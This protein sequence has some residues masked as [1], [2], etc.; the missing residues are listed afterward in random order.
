[1]PPSRPPSRSARSAELLALAGFSAVQLG[2]EALFIK[3]SRY[4]L[5]G[6][7]LGVVGV[8]MLGV[9]LSAPLARVLARDLD[10]AA[11]RAALLLG[12]LALAT[13]WVL[14]SSPHQLDE[15]SEAPGRIALLGLSALAVLA[16]A[17]VP[18][19]AALE[20]APE[21]SDRLYAASLLGAGLGAPL[22]FGVL[23]LGGD[24]VAYGVVLVICAIPAA[25]LRG[26]LALRGAAATTLAVAG[27]V[28]MLWLPGVDRA[29][30]PDSV[31]I[32]SNAFTRID[33]VE[34]DTHRYRFSTAGINAGTSTTPGVVREP[35]G[36]WLL[37]AMSGAPFATHPARVLV[38]GS[39]GGKNVVQAIEAG[40]ERVVGVDINGMIPAYMA[41]H[42]PAAEDP[43]RD[44]AVEL[45]VGEGRHVA[46]QLRARGETFDLVYV[47]MVSLFGSS[48]HAFTQTY[49]MTREAFVRYA[50]LLGDDGVMATYFV[51]PE[52]THAKVVRAAVDALGELGVDEPA[53]HVV[54]LHNPWEREGWQSQ[55][56][57]FV[58]LA[59]PNAPIDAAPYEAA[60]ERG[61]LAR[62]APLLARGA[63]L[64]PLTDDNPFLYNDV[65][66]PSLIFGVFGWTTGFVRVLC[67]GALALLLLILGM[68][69]ARVPATT[70]AR[71]AGTLTAFAVMG[72]AYA[73]FQTFALQ[74]LGFLVGHPM[75]ATVLVLTLALLGTGLGSRFA[76]RFE[77]PRARAAAA[78]ALVASMVAIALVPAIS[79]SVWATS[80]PIRWTLAVVVSVGPFV[81]MG[82]FFPRAL[83]RAAR[84]DT[85][86]VGWTWAL[87][88]VGAVL[89]AVGVVYGSMR[90]GFAAMGLAAAGL[91]AA[92]GAWDAWWAGAPDNARRGHVLFAA[93]GATAALGA[94]AA[95]LV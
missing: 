89:G 43:Y 88:G 82:T 4:D 19:F 85:S 18:I 8:A 91:Y 44:P 11:A 50:G 79:L 5:G 35:H 23:H 28:A 21:R 93:V 52:A 57:V 38:L 46:E 7:S 36:P 63:D 12:P 64:R 32:H 2:L 37:G 78:A 84:L 39:G 48:G 55:G 51:G 6:L 20:R 66:D 92:L 95:L 14:F 22:V 81:L 75:T 26:S 76:K 58:V 60:I 56:T 9:A 13:G 41:E 33:V 27:V 16:L 80:E 47:P 71:R 1:M 68:G 54:V 72:V 31:A 3:L 15:P 59:R 74:R 17:T 53:R 42:L 24:T 62:V 40:A 77:G 70:R 49:L 25:A 10:Q 86:V 90:V 30:H 45:I 34:R 67:G 65:D 29:A 94:A 83:E 87:N 69:T 73:L 61:E